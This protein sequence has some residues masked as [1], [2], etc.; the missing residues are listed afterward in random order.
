MRKTTV[1]GWLGFYLLYPLKN[2]P[3]S[4]IK[5]TITA[6]APSAPYKMFSIN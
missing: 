4:I 2:N 6:I 1:L 5:M 3:P